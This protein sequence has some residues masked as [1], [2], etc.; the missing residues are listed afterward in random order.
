MYLQTLY[1]QTVGSKTTCR[2]VKQSCISVIGMFLTVFK[3]ITTS[4]I[5]YNCTH[6]HI[7]TYCS[8][9]C[10]CLLDHLYCTILY[11]HPLYLSCEVQLSKS[12]VFSSFVQSCVL[13]IHFTCKS[14]TL[15][16][17]TLFNTTCIIVRTPIC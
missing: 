17:I 4:R 2:T 1:A 5:V 15:S 10:F 9:N 12:F 13:V 3:E 8:H 6:I 16:P 11:C 14:S 7:F